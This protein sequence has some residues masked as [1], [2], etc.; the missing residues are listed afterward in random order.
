[1]AVII[2]GV[3][4]DELL[5]VLDIISEEGEIVSQSST[6]IVVATPDGT[7]AELQ[8]SFDLSSA[9]GLLAST[10]TALIAE[11]AAGAT[12]M[13]VTGLNVTFEDIVFA[14]TADDLIELFLGGDD[15]LIG[16]PADDLLEGFGG[17]DTLFG[18][19]GDDTLDGGAGTDTMAGGTGNDT[20]IAN[21]SSD[22]IV[23]S[24]GA[25]SDVVRATASF[26]L[27]GNVER[28]IL[29]GTGDLRGGGNA[30]NNVITGNAGDNVLGG[31]GGAD[32][33]TGG[34]GGDTLAGGTGKDSLLGGTGNDLLD[35]GD[36]PDRMAGGI[37]NDRYIV[38]SV[39][40]L[41]IEAAG[42][43]ADRV[44]S[45]V[46]HAL[47][48]NVETLILLGTGNI[49]GTGNASGNTLTGNSG[50]N[51]LAGGG[52][53]DVVSGGGGSDTLFGGKGDDSVVGDAGSDT[54]SGGE[55]NDRFVVDASGESIV[56]ALDAGTDTV[57]SPVSF[58]L[59]DNVERLI[60][61]G[62]GDIDGTGN[63]LNNFL[64]G[65]AGSNTLSGGNGGDLVEGG[66]SS[67]VL[68]GSDG[69]DSL[70]GQGGSDRMAGGS[71]DDVIAGSGGNDTLNGGAGIDSLNGGDGADDF[72]YADPDDGTF[73]TPNS[74]PPV[75]SG[76]VISDF[77]TGTDE[78]VFMAAPFGFTAGDPVVDGTNFETVAGYDGTNATSTEYAGGD[79]AFIF[80]ST[81][82]KLIYDGNGNANGYTVIADLDAGS[83]AAGDIVL[84]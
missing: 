10:V 1:M 17:R 72:R 13:S 39:D 54:M 35:G 73:V 67:D 82:G 66:G 65:N 19:A 74:T 52:G 34:G 47:A 5:R 29:L 45:T 77:A 23:E 44:A 57:Q 21:A 60:L 2:F 6:R 58:A 30:Q 31:G 71:G 51:V 18:N 27:P 64:Q 12:L 69:N 3:G 7:T 22:V 43:G 61:L 55:G 37:G 32:L 63:A 49:D 9:D 79:D 26:T 11:S 33:L 38:D 83:V 25:G 81:N 36:G 14:Q 70:R 48:D 8:G 16:S 20:F 84:V 59:S 62:N 41:V 46:S 4:A 40:D 80:D 75:A 68:L 15:T 76:D 53:A 78:F 50:N 24:V 28:L 56:E 42:N